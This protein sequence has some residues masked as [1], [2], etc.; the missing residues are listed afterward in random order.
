[1]KKQKPVVEFKTYPEP[2]GKLYFWVRVFSS[3]REMHRYASQTGSSGLGCDFKGLCRSY[4]ILRMRDGGRKS[5]THEIGDILLTKRSLGARV[6]THECV[7]AMY[8]YFQR[9]KLAVP[10]RGD[11]G[12]GGL[13]DSA[14]ERSCYVVGNLASQIYGKVF[15]LGLEKI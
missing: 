6:V 12:A 4:D 3:Q 2:N 8:G 11:R 15:E 1:M 7:H 5:M 13:C 9:K 10:Q 14:E